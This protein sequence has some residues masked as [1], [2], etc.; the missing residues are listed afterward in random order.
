MTN[1][2]VSRHDMEQKNKEKCIWVTQIDVNPTTWGCQFAD[3][4]LEAVGRGLMPNFNTDIVDA[5]YS[6][7]YEGFVCNEHFDTCKAC[8]QTRLDI[9]KGII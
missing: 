4:S 9:A 5:F 8:E 2:Y 1:E 6:E 3:I 7:G